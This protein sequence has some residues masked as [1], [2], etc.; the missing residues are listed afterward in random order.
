KDSLFLKKHW[1]LPSLIYKQDVCY[2]NIHHVE[3]SAFIGELNHAI[4]VHTILMKVYFVKTLHC[5]SNTKWVPIDE[6]KMQ[7]ASSAM[8]KALVLYENF[9][10]NHVRT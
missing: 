10:N 2:G 8:Q 3:K 9:I 4:T 7:M 6:A 5:S 1:G